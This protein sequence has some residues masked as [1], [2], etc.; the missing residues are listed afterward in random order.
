MILCRARTG[1]SGVRMV[2]R[3]AGNARRV[4]VLCDIL[5]LVKLSINRSGEFI[6]DVF[7]NTHTHTQRKHKHFAP[8]ARGLVS[9]R[10]TLLMFFF[11]IALYS[12]RGGALPQAA[13]LAFWLIG[14]NEEGVLHDEFPEDERA[15][16]RPQCASAAGLLFWACL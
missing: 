12:Y 2:R 16:L 11:V 15:F 8:S 9:S 1:R 4:V 6:A 14:E 10:Q 13:S 3:I 7:K 5:Q